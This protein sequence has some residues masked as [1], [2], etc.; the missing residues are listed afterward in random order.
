MVKAGE[1]HL[2]AGYLG[3]KT[4]H[5]AG[6]DQTKDYNLA[7]PY[8]YYKGDT[9]EAENGFLNTT[10]LS[11]R[12]LSIKL[13][14]GINPEVESETN[15]ARTGMDKLNY[16]FGIGPIAIFHIIKGESFSMQL[17]SNIRRE[18]ETD[19]QYTSAFGVT[20]T[21]YLR[22]S[23]K[24]ESWSSELSFG[25][26]YGDV[27]YH[28]YYYEVATEFATADRA[29]YEAKEGNT[30]NIAIFSFKKRIGDFLF[31]PFVRHINI[32]DAVYVDSPLVKQDEY[33]LFGMGFFYL[34]F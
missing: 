4:L 33:Y 32:K 9:V 18:F 2:G 31:I 19:F 28:K 30:G 23:F 6:S 7:L 29:A 26:I 25:K 10:F 14:F 11:T 16:N 13:S 15:K 12:F 3:I 8:V 20:Q 27:G 34:F 21:N 22:F 5:Y 1:L 24:G 17:E